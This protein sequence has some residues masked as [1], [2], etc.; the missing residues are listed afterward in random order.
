MDN[1]FKSKWFVRALSLGF[2]ILLYV[3]V[4]VEENPNQPELRFFGSSTEM[5][6]LDDVP[7]DIRIDENYVVS[8]VPEFVSVTLEGPTSILTKTVRLRNFDVFV[9]LTGL[10]EGDHTV[11]IEYENVPDD[12]SI[13]IEPKTIDVTIE[14]RATEEFP[15]SVDFLNTDK[16]PDGY[17]LGETTID[18]ETVTITSSKS[19]VEQIA[20]VKVF[21]DVADL[22]EPI[23]NREVP[24]NVYDSQGNELRVHIEPENVEV[25]VDV[26]NPSKTVSVHVPTTGDLPDDYSLESISANIDEIEIFAK[27]HI[28]EE[29]DTVSTEE[30]DL[31]EI[32]ES[33]EMDMGLDL[34]D[35]VVTD[36]ST[37]EVAVEI[38]QTKTIA[39]VPIEVENAGNDLNVTFIIPDEPE[40]DLTVTGNQRD[41]D[42]LT[43]DDFRAVIDVDGLD[44]G[45][46]QVPVTVEGPDDVT[47]DGEYEQVTVEVS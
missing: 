37:V 3:F 44:S 9:D 12:L 19:V 14:E 38:E 39:A 28:L 18:P 2:A 27:S 4:S 34:P 6:T 31:S 22:T 40:M 25:S 1:W 11:E 15:V 33:R 30:V 7:V 13:Y 42:R 35:G 17:E 8:G 23:N 29:I 21:V 47:Y 5:Q 24:V 43:V 26:N 36:D 32:T 46:H 20:I 10:E 16:L 45:E 41:V